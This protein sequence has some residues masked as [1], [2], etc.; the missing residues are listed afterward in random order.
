MIYTDHSSFD[1][2]RVMLDVKL[3]PP[4]MIVVSSAFG[5]DGQR[6][7]AKGLAR[8]FAET[9]RDT[10][11]ITS[12]RTAKDLNSQIADARSKHE[13]VIVAAPP[14]L[15]N[16]ASLDLCRIADGVL[17][18][19]RLGRKIAAEDESAAAQLNLVAAK[20]LGVVAMRPADEPL[21]IVG[22]ALALKA[23][24]QTIRKLKIAAANRLRPIGTA[25]ASSFSKAAPEEQDTA[26]DARTPGEPKPI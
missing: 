4:A 2:L 9:G 17:L 20:I 26:R 6:K 19:V 22:A 14:I 3:P 24:P 10:A 8:A 15:G 13:I 25:L 5:N 12:R 1:S 11:F 7:L 23:A 21:A 16:S 18:A